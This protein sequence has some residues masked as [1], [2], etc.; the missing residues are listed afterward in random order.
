MNPKTTRP[1]KFFVVLLCLTCLS[2]CSTLAPTDE[3]S[4]QVSNDPYIGFNSTMHRFNMTA[5]KAVLRPIARGY[6]YSVPNPARKSVSLF[7]RNLREPLNAVNNL[8]QGDIHNALGSTY[9]FVVNSTLGGLG[10]FDVASLY[11]VNRDREDFG[12]TLAAWGV[13][14]GPYL[15][16]PFIG[17]SNLRDS[18]GGFVDGVAY[19]PGDVVSDSGG[20]D[21]FYTALN[22]ISLRSEILNFDKILDSQPDPY[23][24]IKAGYESSRLNSIYDG[25][26][27]IDESDDF[28]DF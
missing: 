26:P 7:F 1:L 14:P 19:F 13:N 23:L 20:G 3:P 15:V 5:D 16:L 4:R 27:P 12:Q 10:L 17:P 9:R 24:F 11:G 6:K 22:V 21:I 2:A 18:F 8:L 25:S 28:D